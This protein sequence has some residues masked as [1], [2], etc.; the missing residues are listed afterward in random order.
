M[1]IERRLIT[2]LL[3]SIGAGSAARAES[4]GR[5]VIAPLAPAISV[6]Q[7]NGCDATECGLFQLLV[8]GV[9]VAIVPYGTGFFV[10]GLNPIAK[11]DASERVFALGRIEFGC[12]FHE[13]K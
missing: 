13:Q 8:D 12:A 5:C 10:G 6:D 9:Q 2:I 3:V 11:A 4:A 1:T 7:F